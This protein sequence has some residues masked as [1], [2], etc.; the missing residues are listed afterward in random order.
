MKL[1]LP[2]LLA[3]LCAAALGKPLMTSSKN[4]NP[5]TK[6]AQKKIMEDKL[7]LLQKTELR[8]A[9][10]QAAYLQCLNTQLRQCVGSKATFVKEN[11]KDFDVEVH[12]Y[13]SACK[14]LD[15]K[16]ECFKYQVGHCGREMLKVT[17]A[18]DIAKDFE[19]EVSH[20][21]TRQKEFCTS[22][23][24]AQ[25]D[26]CENRACKKYDG[27]RLCQCN[28]ACKRYGDCCGDKDEYCPRHLAWRRRFISGSTAWDHQQP[29]TI[30]ANKT[31]HEMIKTFDALIG[32]MEAAKA[33]V[34]EL[35][36]RTQSPYFEETHVE[37]NKDFLKN[38]KSRF[39]EKTEMMIKEERIDKLIGECGC[40]YDEC[41]LIKFSVGVNKTKVV[42]PCSECKC[43]LPNGEVPEC[44][45]DTCDVSKEGCKD[46]YPNKGECKP[47]WFDADENEVTAL[48][49]YNCKEIGEEGEFH[50]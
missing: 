34:E 30:E 36:K 14:N 22:R 46:V 26:D 43:E 24:A 39:V 40:R 23:K 6:Y 44:I 45:L 7:R 29:V 28:N 12:K 9:E 3:G 27:Q 33:R 41:T 37:I 49:E 16:V 8:A 21:E 13:V 31:V 25:G 10:F 2:L 18:D 1:S 50:V 15:K 5:Y 4:I 19:A 42:D 38:L 20:W 48:C 35:L 47:R 32:K 11:M 17:K